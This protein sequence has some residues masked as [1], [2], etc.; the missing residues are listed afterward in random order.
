MQALQ[1]V[2]KQVFL[3]T[4]REDKSHHPFVDSSALLRRLLK[5]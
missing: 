4:E 3:R 1:R 5:G 2:V